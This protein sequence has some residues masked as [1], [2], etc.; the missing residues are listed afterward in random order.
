MLKIGKFVSEGTER[1]GAHWLHGKI[2]P[3]HQR[4]LVQE[5]VPS[6]LSAEADTSL[7]SSSSTKSSGG[8]ASGATI[9][10]CIIITCFCYDD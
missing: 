10:S 8:V 2:T 7:F 6:V 3:F 4:N 5:A 9:P 1:D